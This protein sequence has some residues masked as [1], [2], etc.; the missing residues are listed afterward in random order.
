VS[1]LGR[2]KK[3]AVVVY[4]KVLL[5]HY[6]EENEENQGVLYGIQCLD[7]NINRVL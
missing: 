2:I 6:Y 4:F 1:E 5:R 7:W 3:A